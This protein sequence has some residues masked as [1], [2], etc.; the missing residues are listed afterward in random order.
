MAQTL[1]ISTILD[2]IDSGSISLPVF[3]RGYVWNRKQV[4]NLFNSLYKEYPVGSLL[5]W[6]TSSSEAKTK[7]ELLPPTSPKQLLLDGQQRATSLYGVMRGKTPPF[8]DG[9]ASAFTGL[10]FNIELEV[11]RFYQPKIMKENPRWVNVTTLFQTG[12]QG[13]KPILDELRIAGHESDEFME[14]LLKLN[15]ILERELLVDLVTGK[16]KTIEDVVDIFNQVNTGGTKLSGGDLALAKICMDWPEARYIMQEKLEKWQKNGYYF[17]LDWFLR[18]VNSIVTGKAKLEFLPNASKERIEAGFHTSERHIDKSLNLIGGRLGL[19]HDQVLFAKPAITLLVAFFDKF[20]EKLT[21]QEQDRILY[22]YTH[23]G[24]WGRYSAASE[25][26]LDQD[27]EIVQNSDSAV[28]AITGLIDAL[29]RSRGGLKVSPENFY[30][31]NKGARFYSV[32][33]MITRMGEALDLLNGLPLKKHNLGKMSV[34]EV[35][36]IFPKSQLK[37]YGYSNQ[38]INALTNFCFL[39]KESNLKIGSRLPSDY[40][41]EIAE[42]NPGALESQ[43][44]PMDENLWEM[45]RYLDFISARQ[46]ILA[47]S[48]NKLLN[49]L[50]QGDI[51]IIPNDFRPL[52]IASDEEATLINDLNDWIAEQGLSKGE[53]GYEI[54]NEQSGDQLAVL[55]LAWPD[56]VQEELS[57]P[58]ALLIDEELEV[59]QAA[60]NFGFRC[61]TSTSAFR[62]YI[63]S[64][65][66]LNDSEE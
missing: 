29:R 55:D 2:E 6:K 28:D 41:H 38:E 42:D 56:G 61:F 58:V 59:H 48:T 26:I 57:A 12:F 40:F 24:M 3:Q 63:K 5:I 54:V 65:I 35:H 37:N 16:D 36:H 31:S 25:T 8:F 52:S 33:Y 23:A 10:Y 11:F 17:R 49:C 27:L 39:T 66:L 62:T 22:W 64:E 44:I 30:G 32:L 14:R 51:Q 47:K 4:S 43:W 60:Q 50:L 19:D 7:G 13:I 20:G 34:L 45:D 18:A 46:I 9:N 15:S 21:P 53:V 1:K